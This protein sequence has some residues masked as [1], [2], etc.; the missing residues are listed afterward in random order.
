MII[1]LAADAQ[2]RTIFFPVTIRR[3]NY[4]L[5]GYRYAANHRVHAPPFGQATISAAAD[6]LPDTLITLNVL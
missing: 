3:R 6:F 1:L 5:Q 4:H 2:V